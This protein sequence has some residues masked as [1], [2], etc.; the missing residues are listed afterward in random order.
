LITRAEQLVR[1]HGCIRVTLGVEEANE[2]AIRLYRRL[3]YEVCG[4]EAAEWDQEAPDGTIYRYRCLCL[5]LQRTL[6]DQP[7]TDR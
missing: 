2:S 6:A 1:D 3:G 5:Q 4:T 7:I